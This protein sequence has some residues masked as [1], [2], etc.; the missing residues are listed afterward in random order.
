MRLR[1]SSPDPAFDPGF[2]T[3]GVVVFG[4]QFEAIVEALQR[5]AKAADVIITDS[6]VVP[7]D[8]MFSAKRLRV[9]KKADCLGVFL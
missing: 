9:Q 3:T 7:A 4:A 1:R 6:N 5:F 8:V 2:P